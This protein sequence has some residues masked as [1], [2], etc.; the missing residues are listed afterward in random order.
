MLEKVNFTSYD[1]SMIGILWALS[2]TISIIL[3]AYKNKYFT[4]II[5]FALMYISYVL[6]RF[7]YSKD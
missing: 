1:Y 3:M 2:Y 7:Y 5:I 6:F 4:T